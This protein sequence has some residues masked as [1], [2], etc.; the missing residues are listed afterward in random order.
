[1]RNNR[2]LEEIQ[3]G[4]TKVESLEIIVEGTK[5]QPYYEIKYKEV[6]SDYYCIGY[7]SYCLEYVFEWK[8]QCFELV[9]QEKHESAKEMK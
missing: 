3:E 7:G 8:E 1:M 6:G 2:T 5:E 4:K 9:E